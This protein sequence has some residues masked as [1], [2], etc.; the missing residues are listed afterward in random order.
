[1]RKSLAF[2]ELFHTRDQ[3]HVNPISLRHIV[4]RHSIVEIVQNRL[5][6][7]TRLRRIRVALMKEAVLTA[8]AGS[9]CHETADGFRYR[10]RIG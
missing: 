2:S 5:N 8:T 4:R 7:H 1:M 3:T 6:R 10:H 9:F